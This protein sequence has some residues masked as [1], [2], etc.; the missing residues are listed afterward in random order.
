MLDVNMIKLFRYTK[1][2]ANVRIVNECILMGIGRAA[3]E[4]NIGKL[5]F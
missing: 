4:F 2:I 3:V 5:A 1:R